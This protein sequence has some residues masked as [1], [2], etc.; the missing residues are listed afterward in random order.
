[1]KPIDIVRMPSARQHA[2][3]LTAFVGG[4]HDT[5]AVVRKRCEANRER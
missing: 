1:M 3:A 2:A 5:S 4:L